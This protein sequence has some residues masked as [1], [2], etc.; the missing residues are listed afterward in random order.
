MSLSLYIPPFFE[1]FSIFIKEKGR[2]D[3]SD[4]D[5]PIILF[6]SDNTEVFVE[7]AIG[8]CD[9]IDAETTALAKFCMRG[10][11]VFGDSDDVDSE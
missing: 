6:F 11:T 3:D 8:V 10:F 1:D 5:L 4:I 2:A 9:E 7:F